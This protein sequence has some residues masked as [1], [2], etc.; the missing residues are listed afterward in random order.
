MRLSRVPSGIGHGD[1]TLT[2]LYQVKWMHVMV[3]FES[4]KPI[5]SRDHL[6]WAAQFAVRQFESHGLLE[7]ASVCLTL[8]HQ[9]FEKAFACFVRYQ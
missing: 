6:F 1:S 8:E 9:W 4:F 5:K 2:Y 3:A 7:N